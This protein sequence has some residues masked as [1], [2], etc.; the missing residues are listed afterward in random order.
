MFGW[1]TYMFWIIQIWIMKHLA[2]Y[3][4]S[5]LHGEEPGY[6][7]LQNIHFWMTYRI[8]Q[9]Y[10]SSK[11]GWFHL[12]K[13]GVFCPNL[14]DNLQHRQIIRILKICADNIIHF[15]NP[16]VPVPVHPWERAGPRRRCGEWNSACVPH[17]GRVAMVLRP[18]MSAKIPAEYRPAGE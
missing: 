10:K 9:I 17:A 15:W 13:T 6:T 11:F 7:R 5:S 1:L 18:G 12:E 8:I 16:T 3:P 14:D 2:S 4:G